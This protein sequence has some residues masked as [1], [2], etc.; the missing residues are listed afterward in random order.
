MHA[1]H[2]FKR[3]EAS[4]RIASSGG[5]LQETTLQSVVEVHAATLTVEC[6]A[7]ALPPEAATCRTATKQAGNN[8]DIP[9]APQGVHAFYAL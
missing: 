4:L 2:V 6:A 7:C 3:V 5:S 1:L 9:E 8:C